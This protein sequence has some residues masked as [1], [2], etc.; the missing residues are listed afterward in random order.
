MLKINYLKYFWKLTRMLARSRLLE[1]LE[2]QQEYLGQQRHL[3]VDNRNSS[4]QLGPSIQYRK[5]KGKDLQTIKLIF[6]S[7]NLAC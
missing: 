7:V 3:L 2:I 5:T 1:V 4:S 6:V